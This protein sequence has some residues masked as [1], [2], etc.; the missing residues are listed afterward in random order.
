MRNALLTI[1]LVAVSSSA[2]AL[3]KCTDAGGAVHYLPEIVTDG[4]KTCIALVEEEPTQAAPSK[5]KKKELVPPS[6]VRVRTAKENSTPPA[7]QYA[8]SSSK[9]GGTASFFHATSVEY[10]KQNTV[11][12]WVRAI[13][14]KALDRYRKEHE[15]DLVEI[16]A[17]RMVRY[18]VPRFLALQTIK[19]KYPDDKAWIDAVIEVL[20]LETAANAVE[21]ATSKLYFEIDC[22]EKQMGVLSAAIFKTDGS[23][24]SNQNF[25]VPTSVSHIAPDTSGEWLSLMLCPKQ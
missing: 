1:A 7:W 3:W 13:S 17:R 23:L 16:T 25:K 5:S 2:A 9:D 24:R 20:S 8:G 22:K 10:P 19:D 6:S 12:F 18:E 21:G 11:R 14:Q 4:S 15:K